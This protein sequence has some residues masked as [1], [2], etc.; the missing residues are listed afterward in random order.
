MR[1]KSFFSVLLLVFIL[2]SCFEIPDFRG[3][4]NF[5]MGKLNAKEITFEVDVKVF[6]PNGYGIRV[7]KSTFDLYVNDEY[8]GEAYV[9]RSFK[10]KRKKETE[11]HVPVEVTLEPGVLMKLMKWASSRS[12]NVRLKGVLKASVLGIPKREKID[13]SKNLSLGDLNLNMGGMFGM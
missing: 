11:C 5:K 2:S 8:V 13:E 3:V 9:S 6:N 10:M 12:V 1:A 7:R 4:S